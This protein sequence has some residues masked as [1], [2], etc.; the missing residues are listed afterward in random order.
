MGYCNG[1]KRLIQHYLE[2]V[3]AMFAGM[4]AWGWL[5]AALFGQGGAIGMHASMPATEVIDAEQSVMSQI[6]GITTMDLSMIIP[7]VLWLRYRGHSWRHGAEMSAAMVVPAIPVYTAELIWPGTFGPVSAMLSHGAMLSGMAALMIAQ[8][9]VYAK[10][11]HAHAAPATD[12]SG[13]EVQAPKHFHIIH[14]DPALAKWN[15]ALTS[16]NHCLGFR[17]SVCS[18]FNRIDRPKTQ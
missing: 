14:C 11:D 1:T 13:Q 9:D 15:P 2:M 3:I 6:G 18:I 7:I 17:D 4:L 16:T 12:A 10:Y 8:R 5:S